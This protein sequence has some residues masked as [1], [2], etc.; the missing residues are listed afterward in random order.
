MHVSSACSLAMKMLAVDFSE[1]PGNFF[2]PTRCHSS[3]GNTLLGHDYYE[4]FFN[5][6]NI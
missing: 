3:E 5:M 2:Q 6:R 1:M 4:E